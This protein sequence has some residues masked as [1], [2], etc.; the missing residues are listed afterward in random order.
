MQQE[1]GSRSEIFTSREPNAGKLKVLFEKFDK[2][3]LP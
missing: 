3:T 2:I 1:Y